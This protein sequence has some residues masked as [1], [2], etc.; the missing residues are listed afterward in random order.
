VLKLACEQNRQ[1]VFGLH[2]GPQILYFVLPL[3]ASA[4]VIW[5]GFRA[6][7]AWSATA[8]GMILSGALGNVIDRARFGYVIDFIVFELRRL[9]F[10]WYTFN[11]ADAF[12]VVGA[13]MLLGKE[14]LW[15]RPAG[16]HQAPISNS[17]R[18]TKEENTQ[19]GTG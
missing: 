18:M 4:L 14:F 9:G 8:F 16:N 19:A 7:D 15:H 12:V 11:L 13:I 5:Y 10:E 2:Y 6:K 17:Q 1:G 3:S